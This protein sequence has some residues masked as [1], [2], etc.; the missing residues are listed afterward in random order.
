MNRVIHPIEQESFRRLRARLDT[1]ALAPLSRAVVERVIHSAA[2]LDYA[3]DLVLAEP[4][5]VRAH[6]ALHAGAPVVVDVEM[7]AA[8]ITRRDT[9]CR[10][11]DAVAGPGL[12]RSAHAV[13]LAHEQVGPGAVWVIGCAPTALE[14]LLTLD[15]DPALVIGLPVGFVG[16]AESKAALRASGLPAVS[17]VSEKGGSA[18]AA[19]ALNALLYHPIST[20]EKP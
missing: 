17:N 3:A 15:A 4:D 6:A 13:R 1:S 19:A 20:E 16:A 7:V 2:D 18:V 9:V 10:L 12:T 11:R 8:G 14:E 5:L